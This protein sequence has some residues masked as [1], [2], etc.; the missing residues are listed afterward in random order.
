VPYATPRGCAAAYYPEA[1]AL[2]PLDSTAR[3]SNCPTS[4]SVVIRLM[5]VDPARRSKVGRNGKHAGADAHHK[6]EVQPH[7]LS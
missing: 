3:G 6:S 1:N 5:T 4:K 2:V 7:H